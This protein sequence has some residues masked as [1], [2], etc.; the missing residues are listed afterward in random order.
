MWGVAAREAWLRLRRRLRSGPI[1]RW[2]YSGRTPERVLI[3]PPDLRR[4]DP[5]VASEIYHGRFPLAGQV[6]ETGGRS[7]FQIETASIAWR[8]S[9]HGFRWL[10]HMHAAQTELAAS[11]ARALVK[12]W[13]RL[14]PGGDGAPA[15]RLAAA[16]DADP[17]GLRPRLLPAL[18]EVAGHADP[19]SALGR[20]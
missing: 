7:P 15:D 16:F 9:L 4:A 17:A 18:P 10:R 5:Q 13:H 8:R 6:V 20:G 19:L 14:G 11:N 2:R 1:H 3:A 12:E